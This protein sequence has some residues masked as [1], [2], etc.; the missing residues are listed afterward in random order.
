MEAHLDESRQR[1]ELDIR[2]FEVFIG[3]APEKSYLWRWDHTIALHAREPLVS[4]LRVLCEEVCEML[5]AMACVGARRR[6]LSGLDRVQHHVLGAIA[7][8]MNPHLP[9]RPVRFQNLAVQCF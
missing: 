2:L 6:F 3:Q 7:I 1:E 5:D 9:A 8:G 4:S